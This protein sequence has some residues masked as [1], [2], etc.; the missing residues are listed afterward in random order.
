[1][2]GKTAA[3]NWTL[4]YL[5][6]KMRSTAKGT[7]ESTEEANGKNKERLNNFIAH[8]HNCT[9]T[10]VRTGVDQGD[11]EAYPDRAE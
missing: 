4:E 2:R 1:M 3:L 9:R 5:E 10:I 6:Q 11:D 8:A 7:G